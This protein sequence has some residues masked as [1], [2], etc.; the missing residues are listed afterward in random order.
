MGS[1]GQ[2]GAVVHGKAAETGRMGAGKGNNEARTDRW[3]KP[4]L[5]GCL[6]KH[7]ALQK[8]LLFLT[9]GA[10]Q[11]LNVSMGLCL[12]V[13]VQNLQKIKA[14]VSYESVIFHGFISIAREQSPDTSFCLDVCCCHNEGQDLHCEKSKKS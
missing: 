14:S 7:K 8:L 6:G 9:L 1:L 13:A 5:E 10:Y 3:K 2:E 4:I 12:S 11:Q